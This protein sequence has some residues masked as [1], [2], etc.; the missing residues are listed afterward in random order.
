MKRKAVL[1]FIYNSFKDPLFQN[2]LFSY[3]KAIQAQESDFSFHVI[4]FEQ[5][6]YQISLDELPQIHTDLATSHVFWYPQTFHTGRLLMLK[7]A[8]DLMVSF[9]TV[10]KLHIRH[11]IS[12]IFAFA[13]VSAAFSLVLSRLFRMKLLI[14]SYEPHSEFMSELGVWSRKSIQYKSLSYL[15]EKAGAY[16]D[17]ILTG[18]R[19]M[20]ERLQKRYGHNHVFRAPTGVDES[21]F[22]FAPEAREQLRHRFK[23]GSRK[24]LLYLGKFGDLYYK[25]EVVAFFSGLYQ[26]DSNLFF[27]VVT[28]FDHEEV[29]GWFEKYSIPP[30][31]YLITGNLPFEEVPAFMSAADIGISA[32]PPSPSQKFRSPT[33]VGEY[34]MCGLPIIT[35]EGV[36]ED[37]LYA[38]GERVGIVVP[39]FEKRTGKASYPEVRDLLNENPD[40]LRQRCRQVGITYRSKAAVVNLITTQLRQ[41][42][43]KTSTT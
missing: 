7:K 8:W 33:K 1:L 27:M 19:F 13:N 39:Y 11:R 24:A 25:E 42:L 17:V 31:A 28:R 5:P 41:L 3:I 40:M 12:L 15:E 14:Y 2:I 23:I 32:V 30:D 36:S 4:T 26:C 6:E 22:R 16:A 29:K 20:V 38:K 9:Y 18:T 21:F 35:C 37:D 34:L 43:N 10:G